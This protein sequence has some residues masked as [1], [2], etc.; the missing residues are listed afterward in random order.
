VV[1][2][3][4]W[5]IYVQFFFWEHVIY[6]TVL[7]ICVAIIIFG[8]FKKK[9]KQKKQSRNHFINFIIKRS[10]PTISTKSKINNMCYEYT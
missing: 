10:T 4:A 6:F 7:R 5:E 3:Y 1:G 8:N 9:I 2:H